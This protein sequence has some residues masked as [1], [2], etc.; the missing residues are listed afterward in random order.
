MDS[1]TKYKT[2]DLPQRFKRRSA[3]ALDGVLLV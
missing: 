3:F 1:Q 2:K